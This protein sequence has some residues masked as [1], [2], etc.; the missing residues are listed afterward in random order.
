[1]SPTAHQDVVV[2]DGRKS[3]KKG[4]PLRQSGRLYQRLAIQPFLCNQRVLWF[5]FNGEN[6][7][8]NHDQWRGH[9]PKEPTIDQQ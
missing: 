3:L 6:I 5:P 2:G 1:V 7:N 4:R 9:T 8:P